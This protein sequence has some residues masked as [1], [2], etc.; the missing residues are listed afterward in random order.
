MN[1]DDDD[2]DEEEEEIR[3]KTVCIG[4]KIQFENNIIGD[5]CIQC[6]RM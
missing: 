6:V 2:D 3:E 4:A 5:E 1:E